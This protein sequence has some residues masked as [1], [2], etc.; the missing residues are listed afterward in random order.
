MKTQRELN[1]KSKRTFEINGVELPCHVEN[2]GHV[3]RIQ[4]IS[5]EQISSSYFRFE[6][7]ADATKVE[8]A[9]VKLLEEARD[10]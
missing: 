10:K 3:I 1:Q 7:E 2:E 4:C 6:S 5:S 8:N 9:I